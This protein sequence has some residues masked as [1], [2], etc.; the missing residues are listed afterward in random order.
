LLRPR[1]LANNP[2]VTNPRAQPGQTGGDSLEVLDS[3]SAIGALEWDALA[4]E[5]PFMR[6]AFLSALL[7][8]GCAS[9][10]TGWRPQFLALRRNGRLAGAMPLFVKSHSRGE[11][12]FDWSWAEAYARH[13]LSY[14]PKLLCAVPFTPVS[15]ARVLAEGPQERHALLA[16]AREAARDYSSLHVLF[17]RSE[18]A[19]AMQAAGLSLRHSVQFHWRNARYADFDDFLARLSHQ[20]R[21]N[22]RQERRRVR[23]AGISFRRLAGSQIAQRDWEHFHRCYR[24]TYAAHGSSPY[25]NLDFFL[26]LGASMPDALRLFIAERA[27]QPIAAALFFESGG[28]LYGRHWGT[29]EPVPLLHFECCYYQAIEYAIEQGL[30]VFEGG[31][32]G[33]HKIFRGLMPV[34]TCSAHWIANA[35]F[36]EAIN[37]FLLREEKGVRRY[38]DELREHSPYRER[39]PPAEGSPPQ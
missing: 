3:L 10:R 14:Y 31:A 29:F 22:I 19:E 6:H 23:D 13:G 38:V 34:E 39:R 20:R 16:A 17:P 36:A 30:E 5:G 7:E 9:A 35:P 8:S 33:E 15:G 1:L 2:R 26:R 18:D 27:G 28:S 32:Q 4:G 25:L 11:Y 12:V 37:E 24:S 21:K